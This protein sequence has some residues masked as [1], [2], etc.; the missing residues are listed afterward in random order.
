MRRP[1]R[2]ALASLLVLAAHLWP[3][4]ASLPALGDADPASDILLAAPAF[5]PY[6]PPVAMSLQNQLQKELGELQKNGLNLKVAIIETPIDLAAIP[7]MF[8]RPQTYADFLER[9]ISFN[10]PQ[11]LLV[12]MPTGFGI[13]NAVPPSAL[14]GL[15][16]DAASKSDG[17]T[18]S[19]ILAVQRI[20]KAAGKP[21]PAAAPSGGASGSGGTSP[22]ISFGAPAL[23]VLLAVSL[24]ALRQR[25]VSA[26]HADEEDEQPGS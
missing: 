16:V 3:G 24:L 2:I 13:S 23:V 14:S 8:G 1:R 22:L 19:A 9:E 12:V 4:L 11:P 26:V 6:Q 17:L 25:R 15:K 7:N 18:R 21:I 20:A 5:Y 10:R